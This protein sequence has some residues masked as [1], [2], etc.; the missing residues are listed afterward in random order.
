MLAS[1]QLEG[2]EEISLDHLFSAQGAEPNVALAQS[3]GVEIDTG[4]YI[5]ADPEGTTAVPGV[6]AAGDVTRQ[7]A[8][9]IV[10]AA[11]EGAAAANALNHRLFVQDEEGFRVGHG[12]AESQESGIKGQE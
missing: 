11:H 4:G 5:T 9:Q 8:H 3:L 6:Y 12:Q 7:L 1:L 10:T 2:G